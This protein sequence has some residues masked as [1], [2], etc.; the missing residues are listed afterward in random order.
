MDAKRR[1]T[2]HEIDSICEVLPRPACLITTVAESVQ[3]RNQD[4][5]KTQLKSVE[6]Y[7]CLIPN[8]KE[9]IIKNH[10]KSSIC[11]GENVG[12]LTAQSIGERQT[13]LTLDSFHSAGLSVT[14]VTSG[15]PRLSE[16]LNATK[17]P[18]VRR[19]VF[20][21]ATP[22]KTLKEYR[23]NVQKILTE[24]KIQDLVTRFQVIDDYDRVRSDI[25]EWWLD[26]ID[27]SGCDNNILRLYI[28]QSSLFEHGVYLHEVAWL[29]EKSI[30]DIQ[31]YTSSINEGIIDVVCLKEP[32]ALKPV[33]YINKNN[34]YRIIYDEVIWPSIKKLAVRGIEGVEKIEIL[35]NNSKLFPGHEW[36][37]LSLGVNFEEM[38]ACEP[39]IDAKTC[40]SDNMWDIYRV[41]GIEA[42]RQFLIEEI[43][44]VISSD[45]TYIHASHISLLVDV[46]TMYGDIMSISRYSVRS[47]PTP[48]ARASF[49][50]TTDNFIKSGVFTEKDYLES[51]SSNV[52]TAKVAKVGTGMCDILMD[53]PAVTKNVWMNDTMDV[54]ERIQNVMV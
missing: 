11:A 44:K 42:T 35:K 7:P 52:M 31:C 3:R 18:K 32:I 51:V 33:Q 26:G 22:Y 54:V 4:L 8:L 40:V 9:E 1:L 19:C 21:S 29:I 53:I 27:V 16:I 14:T 10:H 17:D 34:K 48:M 39:L 5:L 49:E 20:T 15:V 46:M 38:L 30:G 36:Y 6:I 24:V 50:E 47:K 28:S 43:T 12:I 45:G 41:L 37:C 13:Q 23:E 2:E 25:H